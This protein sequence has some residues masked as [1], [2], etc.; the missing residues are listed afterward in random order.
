MESSKVLM[1]HVWESWP[2]IYSVHWIDLGHFVRVIYLV[3][4]DII[5][6][7]EFQIQYLHNNNGIINQR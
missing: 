3:N 6:A 4:T 5:Y 7:M 1:I 2:P